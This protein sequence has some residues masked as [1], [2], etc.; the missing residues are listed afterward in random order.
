[1]EVRRLYLVCPGGGDT[2]HPLDAR[3]GLDG[4]L[5]P[6]AQRLVCLAGASWSFDAARV[7]LEEFC[8]IAVSDW[9]VRE[10]CPA[11]AAAMAARRAEPAASEPSAAA[12]GEWEFRTDGTSVNTQG[13]W[14]A[15]KTG[16]G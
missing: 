7:H 11:H 2:G 3:L 16:W 6:Q 14:R 10:T 15:V 8:G 5:S 13:G 9:G 4:L 1:V 12:A